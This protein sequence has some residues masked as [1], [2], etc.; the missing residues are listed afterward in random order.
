MQRFTEMLDSNDLDAVIYPVQV[1]T[2]PYI[3]DWNASFGELQLAHAERRATH[4]VWQS[5]GLKIEHI[6]ILVSATC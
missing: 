2:P 6:K 5:A 1:N 4:L 3:G